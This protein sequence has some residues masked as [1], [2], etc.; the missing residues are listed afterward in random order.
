MIYDILITGF[1]YLQLLA[2]GVTVCMGWFVLRQ[3]PSKAQTMN[4]VFIF[5]TLF[6]LFGYYIEYTSLNLNSMI[7]GHKIEYIGVFGFMLGYLWFISEF[8]KIK[9]PIYIYVLQAVITLIGLYGVLT[10]NQNE[11]L[12]SYTA[13]VRYH[14]HLEMKHTN[15]V[16]F[17]FIYGY[18]CLTYM[19]SVFMCVAQLFKTRGIEQRRYLLIIVGSS[20][21]AIGVLLKN[22]HVFSGYDLFSLSIVLMLLFFYQA[23]IRYGFFNSIVLAGENAI[24][25]ASEGIAVTDINYK[26]IFVNDKIKAS[27]P[28]LAQITSLRDSTTFSAVVDGKLKSCMVDQNVYDMRVETLV[29]MGYN[30]GYM[31]WAIDMTEHYTNLDRM[32]MRAETD[33]LTG[34]NNRNSFIERMES[35]LEGRTIG[36]LLMADIDNFKHVNDNYGH[37]IGDEVLIAFS[38]TLK[39]INLGSKIL[40]RLGGDEFCCFFPGITDPVI[41]NNIAQ[42][43]SRGFSSSLIQEDLPRELTISMGISIYSGREEKDFTSLYRETD[44]AMYKAKNKGKNT[45]HINL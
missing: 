39:N 9:I 27:F 41:L 2:M 42:S 30:Q 26:I 33:P 18:Y 3:K 13:M 36:S 23:L 34:I 37:K 14:G 28:E 25:K 8:C 4:L 35:F 24:A 31:I 22:F 45:V 16:L 38:Q 21:P 19:A 10:L 1:R 12:Y 20:I 15:G 32:R 29:E 43:I 11:L 17:Y 40:C 44:E 7:E 5:F 6:Y